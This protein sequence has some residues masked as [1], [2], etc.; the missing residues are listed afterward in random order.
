MLA[1]IIS[2]LM[3]F[4]LILSPYFTGEELRVPVIESAMLAIA[5]PLIFL[6]PLTLFFCWLPLQ[7]AENNSTPRLIDLFK[8]DKHLRITG[9]WGVIF[10]LF[11]LLCGVGAFHEIP[12]QWLFATWLIGLGITLDANRHLVM[13]IA[14]YFNPYSVV[15]MFSNEAKQSIRIE[16]D[17]DLCD[18]IDALSEISLKAVQKHSSALANCALDAQNDVAKTFLEASKSIAHIT[19]A[20]AAQA[21]GATNEV[22]YIMFYLYQ[23]LDLVFSNA[24]KNHIEPTCSKIITIMGKLAI[25]AAKFDISLA[26]APLRFLG[27]F[28]KRAQDEGFEESTMTASCVFT[29]VSKSILNDIDITY[30][31][32]KDPFL[33]IINGM[34]VL[35]KAEFKKDKNIS[36]PLLMTPFSDLKALFLQG[37]AKD[38]QDTP[39]IV[40]NIDRVLGEF[41][42]LQL[43][44]NTIPEI[45][46]T[47]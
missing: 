24:I 39:V 43:V 28:A 4:I 18:W 27:K 14:D 35:S 8:S 12:Q 26:S 36:I 44:M 42:A 22:S 47:E 2:I 6:L 11:T 45:P 41:E 29:E 46:R 34:E 10:A 5:I 3:A 25:E 37:K 38:H 21:K 30:L 15:K 13:R 9:A 17:Q 19:D 16:K 1:T 31:E 33:S 40:Q 32:I 20:E 23:R 7:K